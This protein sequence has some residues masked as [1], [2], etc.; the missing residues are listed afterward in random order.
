MVVLCLINHH[1][2]IKKRFRQPVARIDQ[3]LHALRSKRMRDNEEA[4]GFKRLSLLWFEF[5]EIHACYPFLITQPCCISLLAGGKI[6][7]C[8]KSVSIYFSV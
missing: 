6:V 1:R 7:A 3:A 4:V 8:G 5:N 2:L